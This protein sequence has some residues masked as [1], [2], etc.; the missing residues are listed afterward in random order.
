M[1]IQGYASYFN[2]IDDHGD[3]V[4]PG[5]FKE[6]IR[7]IKKYNYVLPLLNEHSSSSIIGKIIKMKEDKKGLWVVAEIYDEEKIKQL[8]N[9]FKQGIQIGFSIGYNV[10]KTNH[11]DRF[12][13]TYGEISGNNR[14]LESVLL[15]EISIVKWPSNSHCRVIYK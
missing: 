2:V 13:T 9:I 5:A 4:I 14:Q 8:K 11:Y 12:H 15:K 3:I 6:T 10:L 7:L 1:K